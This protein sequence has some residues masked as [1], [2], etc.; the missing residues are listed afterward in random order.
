MLDGSMIVSNSAPGATTSPRLAGR[1]LTTPANGALTDVSS[2]C[3]STD[4]HARPV[5]RPPA[6][7]PP[8]TAFGAC[9]SS[10]AASAPPLT[11][12]CGALRLALGDRQRGF[13]GPHGG[14]RR[15]ARRIEIARRDA[16]DF[17]AGRDRLAAIDGE[18]HDRASDL[19]A[20][21]RFARGRELS[22][23]HRART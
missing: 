20:D 5:P 17:R 18:R 2:I 11:S 7:R 13:G 23:N 9:S 3:C 8:A 15:R 4:A 1:A 6:L 14:L 19:R 21:R 12:D 22:R 10:R 16:R